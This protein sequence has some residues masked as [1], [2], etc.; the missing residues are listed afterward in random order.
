VVQRTKQG[1]YVLQD[2]MGNRYERLI[3]IEQIKPLRLFP[4]DDSHIEGDRWVVKQIVNHYK[5]EQGD[6]IYEVQWRGWDDTTWEPESYLDQCGG[7]ISKY[8]ASKE[9]K[10]D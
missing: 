6:I 5:N 4:I 7:L 1:P 9:R 8:W 10:D 2:L 3:P